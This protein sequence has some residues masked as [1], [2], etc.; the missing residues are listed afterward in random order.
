M[1]L[2]GAR[3]K[4][5]L[6]TNTWDRQAYCWGVTESEV[7]RSRKL[8][9]FP[10][11]LAL[12]ADV[13]KH[14]PRLSLSLRLCRTNP[15]FAARMNNAVDAQTRP[16]T[17][18]SQPLSSFCFLFLSLSLSRTH[19]HTHTHTHGVQLTSE[20]FLQRC[21]PGFLCELLWR[22]AGRDERED[23]EGKGKGNEKGWFPSSDEF[24]LYT[25]RVHG[26][27]FIHSEAWEK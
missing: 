2:P 18:L 4:C 27:W 1:R 8:N 17:G 15:R 11:P 3:C 5:R 16:L 24:R 23:D 13:L 14:S 19:T 20:N 9:S 21:P 22:C 7:R 10:L 12:L 6:D 25:L 26:G